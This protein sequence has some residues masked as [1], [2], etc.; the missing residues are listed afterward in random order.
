MNIKYKILQ[1]D[2]TEHSII[3]RFYTDVLTEEMLS[4]VKYTDGTVEKNDDGTVKSC[5]TDYNINIWQTPSPTGEELDQYILR[6]A[7]V[8]WLELQ[9]SII[10]PQIDTSMSGLEVLV[11]VEKTVTI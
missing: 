8:Q 7:P 10:N 3:V 11:G 5:R 4:S 1:I 6:H 2:T 9:E